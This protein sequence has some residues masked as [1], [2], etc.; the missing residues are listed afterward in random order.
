MAK[1]EK[2]DSKAKSQG[3]INVSDE[4]F[5]AEPNDHLLYLAVVRQNANARRGTAHTKTRME[6]RGGGRKP[7]R[8]KGTGRARAG[9]IRS[10]LFAGGGIIHGPR[11][12]VNWTKGMN[13]KERKLAL[14]SAFSAQKENLVVASDL[15]VKEGKTREFASF[16]DALAVGA[17]VLVIVDAENANLELLRRAASN[18][19][20]LKLITSKELNVV[21][22][23][24]AQKIVILEPAVKEIEES[25]NI[26][27][28]QEIGI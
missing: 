12:N 8:Q 25:L 23:L 15:G 9:S 11:K 5:G 7:W 20:N 6:V 4:I 28:A 3:Q 17:L 2:V 21:D 18:L 16:V 19:V 14:A 1:L 10:P 22:I 24:K 13:K 27:T 26:K